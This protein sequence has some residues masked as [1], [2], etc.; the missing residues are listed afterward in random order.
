MKSTLNKFIAGVLIASFIAFL[1]VGI[2]G[3]VQAQDSFPPALE[4][5]L[6]ADGLELAN[7]VPPL[8]IMADP[9]PQRQNLK[10]IGPTAD[11]YLA[12]PGSENSTFA[13]TYVA[14]G[15][16][17]P[18]GEPC[19]DFPASAKTAF[20]A[21]AAI[22]AKTL[23]SSVPITIKACWADLGS[24]SGIL[25]YSGGAY[26]YQNFT[27]APKTNTWYESSL[28]NALY[29]SDLGPSY[30]DMNI[31]Y[32]KYFTWYYGTDG[33]PPVGTYD[34]V[35]VAAHE[36]AHGLNFSGTAEYSSGT[37]SFGDDTYKRPNIYDTFMEN[38]AGTALTSFT[39]P[40]P[41]L[42]SLLTSG[43]LW[44]DGT[45]ANAANGSTRVKIYAP[46]SWQNG[47]SYSHLDYATF[48]GTANSL[49]VYA[50]GS[51]S[52]QHSPG[53]VTIGIFKD[54]GWK[55]AAAP[56]TP[57]P[58]SPAGAT[59]DTTP[60]YKWTRVATA[61]QYRYQL[62]KGTT[63]VYTKLVGASAC[64]TSYCASTPSNVL[65]LGSYKWRVQAY[66]GGVWKPYS[67]FKAFSITFTPTPI[68]PS[69]T[70]TDTTPTYKWTRLIGASQYRYQLLKGTTLVYTKIVGS[71]RCGTTYC[72]STPSTVLSAGS[73]KWRVQAYVGG[74]WR[75]YSVY[76]AFSLGTGFISDF[77]SHA[78]GWTAV[79]GPWSLMDSNYYQTPGVAGYFSS[80][81]HT[82][83][84]SN[85]TY[86]AKVKRTGSQTYLANYLIIRGTPTGLD[87]TKLWRNGYLF[88]Y[89]NSSYGMGG[90]AVF[91]INAGSPV[92]LKGWTNSSAIVPNDW[93]VLKVAAAG[94]T[95]KFYIN[96]TLVWTGT[97][98]TISA[99]QV[100][101]MMYRTTSSTGDRLLADWAKL[102][103][104]GA[105]GPVIEPVA[106]GVEL[107]GGDITGLTEVR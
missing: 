50:M 99:G 87:A 52:A 32:N 62:L 11:D 5:V 42:G 107:P 27:G 45:N 54:L 12:G 96:G 43:D 25:G 33:N 105:A 97:D 44:F 91:E 18:W 104:A 88:G 63:L 26:S 67:A 16:T 34:L 56:V 60:K 83:S 79:Y 47:S 78:N 90:F 72:T 51:G 68:A 28:A 89:V 7:G 30:F 74:V 46:G 95:L 8:V 106:P 65:T 6:S 81:T 41:Q 59:A 23:E 3:D 101:M 4:P 38:G 76:K 86:E 75:A 77:T 55:P 13:V 64:G 20:N 2:N 98:S 94:S 10:P 35:S 73:Y 17:D 53:P 102:T 14:A 36:I 29:G 92:V 15:G 19:Y 66:A 103:T 84:Y 1:F 71:T 24:Y 93:N 22:W 85:F 69:G 9:N 58:V 37:G 40:S 70:I 80:T 31:T 82:G 39:N 100:G 61:T 49:M 21:A 48:S 57:T